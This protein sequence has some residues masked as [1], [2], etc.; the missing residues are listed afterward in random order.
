MN[1]QREGCQRAATDPIFSF[2]APS[3]SAIAAS[4]NQKL[5]KKL[6]AANNTANNNAGAHS[7]TTER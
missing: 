3:S 1:V 2:T 5:S 7:R 4:K 6:T